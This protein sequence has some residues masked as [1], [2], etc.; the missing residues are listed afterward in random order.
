[1]LPGDPARGPAP[2]APPAPQGQG[3]QGGQGGVPGDDEFG[4]EAPPAP[5][6]GKRTR[7]GGSTGDKASLPPTPDDIPSGQNDDV[8][9]RQLREAAESET[10]PELREKLWEEYRKY[11]RGG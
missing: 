7:P 3:G 6:Q 4:Y 9:A 5:R 10:D 2:E 1:M 11:K 8:V